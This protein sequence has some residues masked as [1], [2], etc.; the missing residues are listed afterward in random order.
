MS[1][2]PGNDPDSK[3]GGAIEAT[4]ND[5]TALDGAARLWEFSLA[6]YAQPGV[7]ATCLDLQE[8]HGLD[9]NMLLLCC[10]LGRHGVRAKRETVAALD[11]HARA[12]RS[13]AVEPLRGLR[14]RLKRDVGAV[15][16]ESAASFRERVKA[17]ELEAERLQQE[18]LY[19]ALEH[20]PGRDA[21]DAERA[22]L[23]RV[24]LTLYLDQAEVEVG[25]ETRAMLERLVG[26]CV[27]MV[28]GPETDEE[29]EAEAAGADAERPE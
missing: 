11:Q 4:G 24:N 23:M 6:L 7:E 5:T 16:A 17:L 9:V 10:F 1:D 3:T 29:V 14:R 2:T 13:V 27:D 12:W 28:L 20:L 26:A 22:G 18:T 21:R 19:R 8:M 25:S 15:S